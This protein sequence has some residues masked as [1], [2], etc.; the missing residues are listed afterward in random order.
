MRSTHEP[1][2]DEGRLVHVT[3]END[4]RPVLLDP[5]SELDIAKI[6]RAAPADGRLAGG[7]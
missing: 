6:P 5:L 3:G 1:S 7:A 4:V 2:G